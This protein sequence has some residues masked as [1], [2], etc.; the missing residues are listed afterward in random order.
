MRAATIL[1]TL[2]VAALAACDSDATCPEG[3]VECAGRCVALA[4]DPL[5]CGACGVACGPGATCGAGACGCGPGTVLCGAT[6]AQLESDPDHCGACGSACRDAQVCS[7]AGGAA[8]CADACGEGQVAC[9]RACVELA[10]DRY[11]CGAC[12]TVC[13]P[14]EACDAGTCRSLQVACFATDDVRPIAPDLAAAGSPR[15]AGDGPIA[16]AA[17]GGDVWAAAALSGSV[18]RLPLDLSAPPVEHA[19]HGSDLEGIAAASDRL[20]VSNSGGGSVAVVDPVTGRVLDDVLIPGLPGANPRGIAVLDGKAYVALYGRDEASGGQGVAVLD[21]SR[22]AGCAAAPCATVER[23][24]DLRG[25]ADAGGLPFPG[26]AVAAGG[27]AWITIANLA[28]DTDP[29]SW[30]YGYYVKPAGPGRLA[31][32]DGTSDA[33]QL[34]SLGDGCRNPG[35]LAVDGAT[36]WVSCGAAGAAGLVPVDVSDPRA[37]V[38][39]PVL[40]TAF[41]APGAV[42]ICRGAGFVADQYTGRVQRFDPVTRTSEET[43]TACPVGAQGWAWAADLLCAP[44]R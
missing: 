14:G 5:N 40:A 29:A 34:V 32:L 23:V 33:V 35:A 3:Q 38:V 12:G 39:G 9:G 1:G 2:A 20:L 11:H 42:A 43:V 7:S 36:L 22:L 10:F 27:R 21:L 30:T 19:L 24:V 44:A 31:A 16:L 17:L 8:A 13:Q 37:P 6:C 41:D 15:P 26:K 25:A 18:I 28:R 4:T